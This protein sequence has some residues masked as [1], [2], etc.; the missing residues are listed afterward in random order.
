[1]SINRRQFLRRSAT[2]V[3]GL[4]LTPSLLAN[5]VLGSSRGGG[6][7]VADPVVVAI[8]LNGG[9]DGLNTVVPLRQYGRYRD[10]RPRLGLEESE[11]LGL[12][13]TN[14]FGLNPGLAALKTMYVDGKVAI[15]N[16]FGVPEDAPGRFDHVKSQ[17]EF[18]TADVSSST[19]TNTG[20]L[21][22]F[23]DTVPEGEITPG[24]DLGLGIPIVVGFERSPLAVD[25][26]DRSD[27]VLS[28]DQEACRA[29]YDRL[30]SIPT[31]ESETAEAVRRT[32][33]QARTQ[34][35]TLR[36]RTAGYAPAAAYPNFDQNPLAFSLFQCAEVL[37]ADL[38]VRAI[39]TKAPNYDTHAAQNDGAGPGELGNH[40]YSLSLVGDAVEAFHADLAAHGIGD[41]VITI[42]YSEFGR[43]PEE[44]N[45]RGTD[46]GWGS[47]CFVIGDTVRGGL[48]GDF[49]GIEANQ[50][51]SDG[52]VAVTTDFRSVYATIVANHLGGDPVSVLNGDFPLLGFLG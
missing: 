51:T 19:A 25:R 21:G 32:R 16:G 12:P 48:Y 39:A 23:L 35:A 41:R 24:L 40:D 15:I 14:D 8:F 6:A 9:N 50:L 28:F 29:A 20:W 22:R 52:N 49:P 34:F 17:I 5:G 10:L 33:L 4:G 38:G 13:G 47:V 27:I 11:I 43:R 1:M 42:V 37:A 26:I 3:V 44:N 31:P 18:Q 7:S 2:G 36:D 45:N 46:H 30:Q